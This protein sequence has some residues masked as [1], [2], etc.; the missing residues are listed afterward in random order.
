M[1]HIAFVSLF[2]A[3]VFGGP[4]QA[5]AQPERSISKGGTVS[6]AEQRKPI[7]QIEVGKLPRVKRRDV[8]DHLAKSLA[9]A[10]P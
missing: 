4:A 1:R 7:L 5:L 10:Q 9:V 8:G 2:I 3:A 6:L